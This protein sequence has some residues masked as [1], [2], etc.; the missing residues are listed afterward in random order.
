VD[1]PDL[2]IILPMYNEEAAIPIVLAEVRRRLVEVGLSYEIVCIDDGSSDRTGA[3]LEAEAKLDTTL[4]VLRFSRNFGKEAAMTAGLDHARGRAAILLDSDLQ[5]PPSLL[6]EFVRRWQEGADVVN[7]VKADRGRES[8]TYRSSAGIFNRLM[9]KSLPAAGSGFAGASDFKLLDRQVIEALKSCPERSR[10]FRGLVAWIGFRVDTV[11]FE[12]QERA[13]GQSKWSHAELVRYS[14]R[15]LLAFSALPLRL[16]AMAGFGMLVFTV[17][18]G[19]WTLYR[20]ARGDTLAGFP[21]VILVDLLLGSL[22]LMSLGV[23]SLYLA[24]MFD[25]MKKRP[26]YVCRSSPAE[27]R[28]RST[29]SMP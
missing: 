11:P 16:I 8:L 22:I 15:N 27:R 18:L 20:Y 28:P 21:T 19:A 7:G 2:S 23:I 9:G 29:A 14:V 12:V 24:E 4:V 1:A 3:L 10:F 13:A 6:A 26:I 25:E 17:G 5:H